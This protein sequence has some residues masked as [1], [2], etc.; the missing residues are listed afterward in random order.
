[1]LNCTSPC[2]NPLYQHHEITIDRRYM[3]HLIFCSVVPCCMDDYFIIQKHNTISSVYIP[4]NHI[5][6]DYDSNPDSIVRIDLLE[7]F[8]VSIKQYLESRIFRI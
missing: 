8:L 7:Y 2:I 3:F 1:M 5:L 4:D 6:I